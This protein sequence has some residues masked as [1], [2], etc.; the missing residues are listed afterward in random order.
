LYK[1]CGYDAQ[2]IAETVHS[3]MKD[4]VRTDI[5]IAG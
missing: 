5:T 1:E 4:K 3:F 2:A